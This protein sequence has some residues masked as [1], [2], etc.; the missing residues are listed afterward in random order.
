MKKE[1]L[2]LCCL[3]AV[4]FTGCEKDDPG[5]IYVKTPG[6]L[7]TL[8]SESKKYQLTKLKLT[9]KLNGS[10]IRFVREMLGRDKDGNVTP[11]KLAILDLSEADI[12]EG[13]G[14]YYS[15]ANSKNHS[16][17]RFM[18]LDCTKLT[19]ITLPN[20]I[21]SIG[22][23][24][25][26]GCTGL[27]IINIPDSVVSIGDNAFEGCIGLTSVTI[28]DGV[29]E[30][31]YWAFWKCTKL[32]AI[33]IP[34][35]VTKLGPAAFSGCTSLATATI[36]NSITVIGSDTFLDCRGL[37]SITIPNSVAWIEKY[38]FGN[39]TGL[40]E[41]YSENPV[42][43]KSSTIYPFTGVNKENCTV[44]VPIGSYEAYK[45]SHIWA[46]SGGWY[47]F[48]NIVEIEMP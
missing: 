15:L 37:T 31:G 35:S 30:I 10:D 26:E 21:V 4:L 44:Y 13:G 19:S 27:A 24:A 11:G 47:E 17:E 25:F 38:A 28:P 8:I 22:Q 16:I 12:V 23:S 45:T 48:G 46:W 1:I 2:I 34:N 7:S 18:F 29:T 43:P 9:G 6:T 40:T 3:F 33:T 5:F 14:F 39:C 20:S 41:I 42:P 32:T 36:S